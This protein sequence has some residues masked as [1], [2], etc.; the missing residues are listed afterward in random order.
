MSSPKQSSRTLLAI[1]LLF[2]NA[3]A[4][5]TINYAAYAPSATYVVA[6]ELG[7]FSHYNVSV[8]YH[9][10]ITREDPGNIELL[11]SD[12]DVMSVTMDEA[13]DVTLNRNQQ[14]KVL[15]QVDAGPE[16][17]LVASEGVSCFEDLRDGTV[18]VEGAQAGYAYATQMLMESNGL[19]Y[20][21][22]STQVTICD[23]EVLG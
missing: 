5:D 6:H 19:W 7:F 9:S 12:Y 18:F 16:L 17:V 4:L 23:S 10:I 2:K 8:N 22:Y 20:D 1:A 11:F 13:L 15:G 21:D 14:V 3:L